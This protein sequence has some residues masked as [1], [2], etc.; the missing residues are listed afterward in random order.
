MKI[1]IKMGCESDLVS[2]SVW[3]GKREREEKKR[4][5]KKKGDREMSNRLGVG[6][7]CE[8]SVVLGKE[9]D[10]EERG[11]MGELATVGNG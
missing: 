3:V 10:E 6:V 2:G 5:N 8:W 4:K 11:K 9:K 1:K 7:D